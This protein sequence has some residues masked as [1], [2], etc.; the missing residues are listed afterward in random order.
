MKRSVIDVVGVSKHFGDLQA[1]D[2]VNLSVAEGELLGLIGHN[3]AGKSTLFKLMLG[4][5]RADRGEIRLDGVPVQAA[6]RALRARIAY[7]PENVVFYDN[8]SGL[9]TLRFFADLKGADPRTCTP[10]LE[11]VGLARAARRAVRGY[12]KGMRQRLGFAQVL[13]GSPDIL[14]LDEPTTGLDPEGTREFYEIVGELK[15]EGVTA[16]LATHNLAEIQERVDT[17]AL[18]QM[19]RVRASGT[20]QSLR[21]ELKLPLGITL[22]LRDGAG[23]RLEQAL[24]RFNGC[25]VDVHGGR[26]SVR[27]AR[28]HKMEVLRA[29]TALDDAIADM[30]VH[31]PSL[32]D[33]FLGYT[34]LKGS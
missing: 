27:C 18:M 21:D 11:K 13:L 31:E 28:D 4:L 1:V 23:T 32:E 10:L 29:I 2:G 15:S 16:V 19:G 30:N 14:F 7:L 26:A 33:V 17:L 3:G 9:E 24:A 12:S 25:E 5:L 34:E 22:A 8:L 6:S 20:V